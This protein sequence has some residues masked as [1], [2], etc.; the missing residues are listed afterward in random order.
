MRLY[1]PIF[2]FCHLLAFREL[3][4]AH[5]AFRLQDWDRVVFYDNSINEQP[6]YTV[7]IEIYMWEVG[8]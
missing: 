7:F 2:L 4:F 6:L 1:Q 5:S 3:M 8:N